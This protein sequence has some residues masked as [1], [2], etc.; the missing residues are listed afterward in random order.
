MKVLH[1]N[2]AA[3]ILEKNSANHKSAARQLE[4][5]GENRQAI[6][7]YEWLVKKYPT[8]AHNY[9]RLMIL[10]RKEK[11]LK[12]E[13]SLINTAIEKF[14]DLLHPDKNSATKKI[15][16]L[17]KSILHAVGLTDKRGTALYHPQPIARWQKRKKILQQKLAATAE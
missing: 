5:D 8:D 14:T 17:S 1:K 16:R 10:Y 12:K 15:A 4:A 9:D 11:A 3:A 13:L 2:K 6:E 7:L